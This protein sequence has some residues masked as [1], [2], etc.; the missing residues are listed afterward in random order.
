MSHVIFNI[1]TMK[2]KI[3]ISVLIM[4]YSLITTPILNNFSLNSLNSIENRVEIVV[5]ENFW[6]YLTRFSINN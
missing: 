2:D 4:I 1:Y 6:D 3:I 5:A